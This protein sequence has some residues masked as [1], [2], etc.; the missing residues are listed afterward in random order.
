[1]TFDPD[2]TLLAVLTDP[3]TIPDPYSHYAKLREHTPIF[4]T[5][6]TGT[7]VFSRFED[8]KAVLRDPRCGSGAG[9][10]GQRR[11]IDGSQRRERTG[12]MSMLM[13]N[14][15]DH[16][17]VRGLVAR[18]FTPRRVEQLR[19]EVTAM[20]D[21][22]LDELDG[23]GDFVDHVAFPLPANVISALVGVPESD[24]AYL[25]PMI[26]DLGVGI[27]PTAS[28]EEIAAAD[29]AG[30]VLTE[31][32]IDLIAKRRADPQDDLLTGMVQ[33]SDGEDK[34]TETEVIVNTLL[35]Y[36]AGFETTTHLLGNTVRQLVANPDQHQ[37]L[38][39]D[40]SLI[41]QAVEEVLRYDPPVQVDGRYVF[42]DIE[43]GGV[44]IP[45]GSS[46]LTLLGA[47]NRDPDLVDD[48]ERFD[49]TRTDTQ[50]LSFGSGIHFCLGA[51]LARLEGHALL[52][53]LLDR[54]DTWEITAEPTWRKRVTLR[55][56]ERLDVAFS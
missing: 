25:R 28:A 37:L 7:W 39:E 6:V 1:M 49:V 53:R 30:E 16:T 2:A 14:P 51:A 8:A 52:G 31:Y 10:E 12:T 27:E 34:L 40:R 48:P 23:E 24:R 38:R 33:A 44:E 36:A 3:A 20:C 50:V 21:Q 45:A 29:A 32:L 5:S 46:T 22:L 15:P 26:S 4:Q 47:C 17:R 13:L 56:V 35:I 9:V 43:V 18:S 55:G 42:D 11:G 54:Y 19:P 41:P